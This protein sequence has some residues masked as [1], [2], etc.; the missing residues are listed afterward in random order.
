MLKKFSVKNYKNFKETFTLDFSDISGYQF[1]TN[2]ITNGLISKMMLYGRN[3]TGKTN[4]GN[5][6]MD[7]RTNLNS[8]E[9]FLDDDIY[10]N[11]DSEDE[12]AEFTYVFLFGEDE[13]LYRYCKRS[14]VEIKEEE[15]I[16]N[17]KRI[18]GLDFDTKLSDFENLSLVNADT[19]IEDRFLSAIKDAS[20]MDAESNH[21]QTLSF[22]RFLIN[23]TAQEPDSILLKLNEFVNG[24]S[25]MR[26]NKMIKMPRRMYETFYHVLE[27]R[28]MVQDFEDFLN[29]MGVTCK[30]ELGKRFDGQPELYFAY[31]KPIPFIV[32]MSSG[33]EA[34]MNLYRRFVI[35]LSRAS[36]IYIDEFD[37]FYHY[38]MAEKIVE[39]L[40]DRYPN[41]QIILT[42]HNTNLITNSIMRPD[43]YFI[44]SQ[45][46]ITSLC[47]ATPRELREGHN[48]E[49]MYI[50]GEFARYE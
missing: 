5:A 34:L 40:K 18:F 39:F 35:N 47:N 13:I 32:N 8:F 3:A 31:K 21:Y 30:L 48:L 43:C 28:D 15:L 42:T 23:N 4:F 6:I 16:I 45:S 12:C 10:V 49:K 2:C 41:S 11:A 44:I 27:D 33:T 26:G 36:F 20:K 17:K 46:G 37:A 38:E 19:L 29:A 14:E 7:I 1:N 25:L 9:I 50:S 22:L 24:M